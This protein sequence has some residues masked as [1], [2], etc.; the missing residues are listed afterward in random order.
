LFRKNSSWQGRQSIPHTAV[1]FYGDCVKMCED[2]FANFGDKRTGWDNS[3]SCSRFESLLS[4][5]SPC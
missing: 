1:T 3:K 5:L 2:L 4:D